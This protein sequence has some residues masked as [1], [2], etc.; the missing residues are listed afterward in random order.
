METETSFLTHNNYI[1][2]ITLSTCKLVHVH[3]FISMFFAQG[4][5]YS[6]Y[7]NQFSKSVFKALSPQFQ[8]V[9]QHTLNTVVKLI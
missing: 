8:S 3:L 7:W 1:S 6:H 9:N 2:T 4:R 5:N